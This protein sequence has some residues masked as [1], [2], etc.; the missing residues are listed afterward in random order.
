M[1]KANDEQMQQ[2]I[3]AAAGEPVKKTLKPPAARPGAVNVPLTASSL[4]PV[5]IGKLPPG[6]PGVMNVAATLAPGSRKRAEKEVIVSDEL[7]SPVAYRFSF[8]G[9]GQGGGRIAAAFHELGYR[10]IAV[11]NTTRTDFSGLPESIPKLDLGVGGAAKDA[12]F[13]AAQL[14]GREEDVWDLLTRAW[15]NTTEYGLVC[16]SLGGGT[17]SGTA[18]KLVKLARQYME[19][20][21]CP[22]RVGAIV[23]LPTVNEG[24]KVAAN[25]LECFHKLLELKVS[26]LIIIDNARINE[27]YRPAMSQLHATANSTVS[28]LLHLFNSLCEANSTYTFDRSEFAQLL[29]GG[30]V[31]MGGVGLSQINSPAD[32]SSAIRDQLTNNVLAEVDLRRG[33]KGACLFVSSQELMDTLPEEYYAAGFDQLERVL[34]S[35]YKKSD[36]VEVVVHRGLTVGPYEGVQVYMMVSELEPPMKR[37]QQLAEKAGGGKEAVQSKLAAFLGIQD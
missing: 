9:S 37:I 21:N 4:P 14:E 30:I 36:N 3:D 12:R 1:P 8:L 16:V 29:D 15:G 34:G 11:M 17:G 19:S 10:R 2:A 6:L 7:S 22:P 5:P 24:Q 31:V 33:R 13:A 35:G 32:I 28:N 18:P 20:K 23:S 25:A 26:P 27:L